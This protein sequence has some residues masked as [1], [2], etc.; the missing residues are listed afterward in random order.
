[1]PRQDCA[2]EGKPSESSCTCIDC[3]APRGRRGS[4]G[5]AGSRA[6]PKKSALRNE[7]DRMRSDDEDDAG[8]DDD[9]DGFEDDDYGYAGAPSARATPALSEEGARRAHAACWHAL[10]LGRGERGLRQVWAPG[11]GR[12]VACGARHE[13]V[14]CP[15]SVRARLGAQQRAVSWPTAGVRAGG[16]AGEHPGGGAAEAS[17]GEGG[18][19]SEAAAAAAAFDDEGD[20]EISE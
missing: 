6:R 18:A 3:S 1:M 19:D 11:V 10:C 7:F 4:A 9:D 13:V 2:C 14:P 16:R 5:K 17:D 15:G 12:K 20:L 8:A